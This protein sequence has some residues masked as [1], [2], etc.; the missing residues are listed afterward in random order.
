M[1]CANLTFLDGR[2]EVGFP[3]KI[4]DA[5]GVSICKSNKGVGGIVSA[6]ISSSAERSW[7]C[8]GF[9]K[10][11]DGIK[12]IVDVALHHQ[13]SAVSQGRGSCSQLKLNTNA[14]RC[15]R[16]HGDVDITGEV[17]WLGFIN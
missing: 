13:Q 15:R 2:R 1:V 12:V 14:S 3:S 11:L 5:R 16:T 10:D 6:T 7:V 4:R 8:I 9:V 17:L